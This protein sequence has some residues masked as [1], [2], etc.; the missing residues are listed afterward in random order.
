MNKKVEQ[1]EEALDNVVAQDV[2]TTQTA[3]NIDAEQLEKSYKAL[4][5]EFTRKCQRLAELEKQFSDLQKPAEQEAGGSDAET[6]SVEN[7]A[8]NEC[9][10]HRCTA[11]SQQTP[12][13]IDENF[14]REYILQNKDI[15]YAIISE[16][17]NSV[18]KSTNRHAPRAMELS[19]LPK[20][21]STF[22][23][24]GAMLIMGRKNN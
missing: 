18:N 5:A 12:I 14:V 13:V 9:D 20:K 3:S 15:K 1:A 7:P 16:Y 2:Q 10:T 11:F 24:C 17:I 19:A 21:P 4:Q 23:E 8:E 6:L 22:E